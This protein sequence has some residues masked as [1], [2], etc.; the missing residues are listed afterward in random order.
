MPLHASLASPPGDLGS[1]VGMCQNATPSVPSSSAPLRCTS[2][3]MSIVP[4]VPLAQSLG[5]WLTLPNP[6]CWLICTIRLGY[7]IQFARQPPKLSGTLETSVAVR[8]ALVLCEETA[9]L[10][11]KDAIEPVPPAEMRQEFYSPYFIVPRKAVAFGQSW[12]CESRIG[13]FSSSHSRCWRRSSSSDASNPRI[14]LQRST[15]RILTFMSR[16]ALDT[17]R[18]FGLRL[19]VGHGSTGSSPS[20]FPCLLVSLRKSRRAPLPHYGKWASGSSTVSSM[21]HAREQLCDHRDLVLRHLSQLGLRVNWEKSKLSPVQRNSFLSMELDSVSV[22]ARLTNERAQSMLTCLSSF[23]GRMV[24]P[25]KHFQRLL[26]HMA[27]AAS[28]AARIASYGTTSAQVTLPSPEMGMSPR[29]SSRDRHANALPLIHPLDGPC[30][31]TGWSNL[32]TSVS[33]CRCHDGCLQCG[34]VH[35]MQQAGSLELLASATSLVAVRP[36]LLA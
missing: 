29:Y 5:E 28:V 9:V 30:P 8:D 21:A 16:F 1:L 4:L 18:S 14:G 23:R 27:S 17:G 22:V 11:A 7:V 33:A 15:W 26:G 2:A 13:P 31:S 12:I 24:V 35:Y 3:G 36:L 25:L 19:R 10:L 6:S 34:L 20:G 32:R